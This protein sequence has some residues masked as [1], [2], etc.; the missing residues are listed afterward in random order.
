M[1][2]MLGAKTEV[3]A[4]EFLRLMQ[5]R[6]AVVQAEVLRSGEITSER[7]FL[8]APKPLDEAFTGQARV[9]LSLN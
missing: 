5:A 1:E 9:N 2:A 7:L 6:A 4:D 3:P 8:M